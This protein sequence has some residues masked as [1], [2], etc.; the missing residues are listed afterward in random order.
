[1]ILGLL[2][3][4]TVTS[5]A[6]CGLHATNER[7]TYEELTP[8]EQDAVTTIVQEL[9]AFSE[10]VRKL[11]GTDIDE[12]VHRERINVSFKG[13]IFSFNI[14]DNTIHVATWENLS[15]AQHAIVQGW[16]D[17]TPSQAEAWYKKFFY[18]FM[19]VSQGAKQYMYKTLTPA[20]V[21]A[22]RSVFNIERDSIRVALA[23]FSAEGRR[24]DM[25]PFLTRACKPVLKDH[26]LQYAH[27]FVDVDVAKK[28]LKEHFFQLANPD[29]PTG[30]MYFMCQ[31]IGMGQQ[32]VQDLRTELD[33]IT[34]LPLISN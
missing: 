9:A 20:W 10:R 19:A 30:Y 16:F 28:H 32:G 31:W 3:S 21:F 25:F 5:W 14:G 29:D 4:M 7:P 1:M 23:H 22:R 17:T 15:P 2:L 8:Q 13:M 24:G 6:G 33:W 12:V 27:L 18:R 11:T 34:N 26:R